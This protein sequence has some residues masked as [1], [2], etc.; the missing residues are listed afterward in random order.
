MATKVAYH[1]GTSKLN[2]VTKRWRKVTNRQVN[3]NS[4][5]TIILKNGMVQH[6]IIVNASSTLYGLKQEVQK[7]WKIKPEDQLYS[8]VTLVDGKIEHKRLTDDN[9]H[10]RGNGIK[11]GS[12]LAFYIKL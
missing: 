11:H 8:R 4:T 1:D 6:D 7:R 12:Y 3:T 5:M 10:L 2:R 9:M